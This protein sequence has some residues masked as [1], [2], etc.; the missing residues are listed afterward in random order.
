MNLV[1]QYLISG[2]FRSGNGTRVRTDVNSGGGDGHT[3][4]EPLLAKP[5]STCEETEAKNLHG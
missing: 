5:G 2:W 1:G 3:Y 4:R